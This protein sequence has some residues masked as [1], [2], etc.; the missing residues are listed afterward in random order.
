MEK[1]WTNCNSA[2]ANTLLYLAN[3]SKYQYFVTGHMVA[4]APRQVFRAL[5]NNSLCACATVRK[6]YNSNCPTNCQ[7]QL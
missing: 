1:V 4:T 6:Y 5:H 7:S 2:F 3:F